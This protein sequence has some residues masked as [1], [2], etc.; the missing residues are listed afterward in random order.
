ML[1]CDTMLSLVDEM[2]TEV[3]GRFKIPADHL[4]ACGAS[5]GALGVLDFATRSKKHDVV[6]VS[7]ASPVFLLTELDHLH[8]GLAGKPLQLVIPEEELHYPSGPTAVLL[9]SDR[10]LCGDFES[11]LVLVRNEDH[12]GA[13]RNNVHLLGGWLA[14]VHSKRVPDWLPHFAWNESPEVRHEPGW[15]WKQTHVKNVQDGEEYFRK[16][17]A[18]SGAAEAYAIKMKEAMQ[19]DEF[20]EPSTSRYEVDEFG[21][22]IK[23]SKDHDEYEE[24]KVEEH[25][26]CEGEG[27][28]AEED[29]ISNSPFVAPC[30]GGTD[31]QKERAEGL[32]KDSRV[33]ECFLIDPTAEDDMDWEDDQE[34]DLYHLNL[35]IEDTIEEHDTRP[36]LLSQPLRAWEDGTWID[37]EEEKSDSECDSE[38]AEMEEA[39]LKLEN[40]IHEECDWAIMQAETQDEPKIARDAAF[41]KMMAQGIDFSSDIFPQDQV[42]GYHAARENGLGKP[43][44]TARQLY[45][46]GQKLREAEAKEF[47][48]QPQAEQDR[49]TRWWCYEL[50]MWRWI[51]DDGWIWPSVLDPLPVEPPIP[52]ENILADV[53]SD[54]EYIAEHDSDSDESSDYE[55]SKDRSRSR[56]RNSNAK[57]KGKGKGTD[58]REEYEVREEVVTNESRTVTV[59]TIQVQTGDKPSSSSTEGPHHRGERTYPHFVDE[60]GCWDLSNPV[61]WD[62]WGNLYEPGPD[63]H[64][65]SGNNNVGSRSRRPHLSPPAH[66]TRIDDAPCDDQERRRGTDEVSQHE[67]VTD[68]DES[69]IR[70]RENDEDESVSRPRQHEHDD[71]G[72]EH[73]Q[74]I[75][76]EEELAR[77]QQQLQL[78]APEKRPLRL[79]KKLANK[80]F[81]YLARCEFCAKIGLRF[82]ILVG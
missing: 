42:D 78:P 25:A 32:I 49:Y 12:I 59:R 41:N 10:A 1:I 82:W 45:F 18:A 5:V 46:E 11:E 55:S 13:Y 51:R 24:A 73:S 50:D 80:I 14:S 72:D 63:E 70:P 71:R 33:E 81:G 44:M 54:M 8:A 4:Y 19:E 56:S 35:E 53:I 31:L 27:S 67:L 69:V 28:D 62:D 9:H 17:W 47:H 79:K 75:D 61:F 36:P 48:S 52:S 58:T 57:A 60:N 23:K 34:D 39:Y 15:T 2:V 7:A 74:D 21:E 40:D 68:G 3:Q 43:K 66:G 77:H 22:E 65:S 16:L 29:L 38:I 76:S 20:G 37:Y 64:A 30:D 26:K 6:A